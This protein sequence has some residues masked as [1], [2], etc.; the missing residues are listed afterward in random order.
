MGRR[1]IN[2]GRQRRQE[3][4]DLA[5][6]QRAVRAER[7]PAQQ[8]Q[9]LDSRLGIGMGATKERRRLKTLMETKDVIKKKSRTKERKNGS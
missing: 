2:R 5:E 3:L 6:Q 1:R 8:I 7:T 9:E 4:R